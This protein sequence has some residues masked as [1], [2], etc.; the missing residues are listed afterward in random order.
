VIKISELKKIKNNICLLA[1]LLLSIPVSS[2]SLSGKCTDSDCILTQLAAADARSIGKLDEWMSVDS[3]IAVSALLN[4][5]I[6]G[7]VQRMISCIYYDEGE[8]GKAIQWAD[9]ARSLFRKARGSRNENLLHLSKTFYLMVACYDSLDQYT[10]Q[11]N[12]VDSC[13]SVDK[14]MDTDYYNTSL[15][16]G[17]QV[18]WLHNK[19]DYRA[20]IRYADLGEAIL[21]QYYHGKDSLQVTTS[22]AVYKVQSHMYL[23]ELEV[24]QKLILSRIRNSG[25]F[26][27]IG[28]LGT[29]QGINASLYLQRG[30]PD[31][32]IASLQ[33]AIENHRETGWSTGSAECYDI[34]A[35]IYL[36]YYNRPDLCLKYTRVALKF[37]SGIDSISILN[38]ISR[39]YLKLNKPDLALKYIDR[40]SQILGVD[41][42][43]H[44]FLPGTL[45]TFAIEK[46]AF[47]AIDLLVSK[48]D[49]FL[50]MGKLYKDS[51]SLN[52]AVDFYIRADQL[53]A[54]M[55]NEYGAMDSKLFWRKYSVRLYESAVEAAWLLDDKNVAFYFFEKSRAI[56]LQDQINE[57]TAMRPEEW[58]KS[59]ALHAELKLLNGRLSQTNSSDPLYAELQRQVL[60]IEQ[61]EFSL[62]S[63]S[64]RS[65]V[66]TSDTRR[67]VDSFPALRTVRRMLTTHHAYINIFNGDSAVYLL[68]FIG[69]K[70]MFRKIDKKSYDCS[71]EDF[72]NGLLKPGV[73]KDVFVKW[74]LNANALYK[75]IF[76]SD[77]ISPGRIIISPGSSHFPF[78]ALVSSISQGHNKYMVDDYA[79][80]YVY[81]TTYLED[82][83]AKLMS[84]PNPN[85]LGVAPVQ[86]SRRLNVSELTGSDLSI[87]KLAE[88]YSRKNMF[89]RAATKQHFLD[90]FYKYDIV[91]LY[92]HADAKG[93]RADPV[94]YFADSVLD[95][96]E[97]V[98]SVRPVT[99]LIVL[100]ACES[101]LGRFYE[102]E[103]VFSFNRAFAALGIPTS[104]VNLWPVDNK[105]TYQLNELFYEFL[106]K[107]LPVDVALQQ[108]KLKYLQTATPEKLMPYYWA[109]SVVEGKPLVLPSPKNN[110]RTLAGIAAF[111]T[112]LIALLV[113]I[114][115]RTQ[116]E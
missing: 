58:K 37:A 77:N 18:A 83:S 11:M 105:T 43:A 9:R 31:S 79:I 12:M 64:S 19:G 76:E 49:V 113:V 93:Q 89:S 99:L 45:L 62:R 109:G 33:I 78:E 91:H 3:A 95:L 47:Y 115:L 104:V 65:E 26:R 66:F 98:I 39:A 41:I 72:Q 30:K 84:N 34:L 61:N 97:L 10:M 14:E 15:L 82:G 13:I 68:K 114:A 88:G 40:A 63:R 60:E 28:Y 102:G 8:Y 1:I 7:R 74:S 6:Q 70:V 50:G 69:D 4:T 25:L 38:T 22:M 80:S 86:Y 56:L 57:N 32:A 71:V 42:A 67:I 16:I 73:Y 21:R 55:K 96:N 51:K 27:S 54:G 92:T 107:G 44:E 29:L 59:D 111:F 81:S 108:A 23:G 48:A 94:I 36:N 87:N 101:G 106:R 110:F 5:T 112:M 52:S 2:Q 103:G 46:K 75:S 90:N 85:I 53:L 20:C 17:E 35:Q 24:A 100:A 116:R